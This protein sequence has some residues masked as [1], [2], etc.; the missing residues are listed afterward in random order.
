VKQSEKGWYRSL[1]EEQREKIRADARAR[2]NRDIEKNRARQR[3]KRTA[4]REAVNANMREYQRRNK[5]KYYEYN[6]ANRYGVPR[7]VI[8]AHRATASVCE[9]CGD[10]PAPKKR[11]AIDHDHATGV[12]RGMLCHTCNLGLGAFKDDVLRI[13]KAALYLAK[14]KAKGEVA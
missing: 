2:Y 13:H 7:A 1:T 10:P 4:N 3:A 5:D 11:L 6:A 12:L 9:I 8:Q 14:H